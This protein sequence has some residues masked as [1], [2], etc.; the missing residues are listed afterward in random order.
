[1]AKASV[2]NRGG[3]LGDG[4]TAVRGTLFCSAVVI[5]L[6]VVLEGS[7]LF[8]ALVCPIW[9]LVG[10][11]RAIVQRPGWCV[12]AARVLIPVATLLL[13]LANY[14][15]QVRIAM[16]NSARLIQACERYRE[17]NGNYPERLDDLV[18]RYLSSIPRAKYC[19]DDGEFK[20]YSPPTPM[21]RWTQIPPYGR[22]VYN[23]ETREWNYID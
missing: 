9:F 22:R 15:L 6:D 20:Y 5:F 14:S 19:L 18:P 17:A 16:A 10:V 21:L 12:A 2:K 1:M 3:R 13:V 23:F 4:L 7:Y 11:V 8:A